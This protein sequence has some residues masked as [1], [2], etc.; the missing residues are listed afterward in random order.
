MADGEGEGAELGRRRCWRRE[1]RVVS[2]ENTACPAGRLLQMRDERF[3]GQRRAGP[4][5]G[6]AGRAPG[7]KGG[8]EVGILSPKPGVGA[9]GAES[10]DRGPCATRGAVRVGVCP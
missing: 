7:G 5:G 4:V 6:P 9:G 8:R 10:V 3:P 2:G 1:S